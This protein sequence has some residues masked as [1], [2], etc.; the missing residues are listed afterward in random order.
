M[1]NST[2]VS[3]E[4]L[5]LARSSIPKRNTGWSTAV[6]AVSKR[7]MEEGVE[8]QLAFEVALRLCRNRP[9]RLLVDHAPGAMRVTTER[10]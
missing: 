8:G 5:A 9:M 6:A 3:P 4:L 1:E 2:T 7:L 10:Y